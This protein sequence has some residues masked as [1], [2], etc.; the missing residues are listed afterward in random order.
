MHRY[1]R[2]IGFSGFY[3]NKE[4]KDIIK[5][6]ILF[7]DNK[8][9]VLGK[10]EVIWAEYR[11]E[12]AP[13]MG[14]AVCGEYTEENEFE[15]EYYFPYF[16]SDCVSSNEEISVEKHAD[17]DSFSGVCEDYKVGISL[18]FYLQNRMD[19]LKEY[20]KKNYSS[21]NSSVNLSGLSVSG[22]IML[23]LEKDIEQVRKSNK[24]IN[25]RKR[26][27]EKA[28]SGDEKA[29]ESLTLSDMDQ[30]N[31]VSKQVLKNDVFS[32]VDTTFMPYGVECDKYSVLG[33]IH[34]VD[35][36]KNSLTKEELYIISMYCNDINLEVCI[37]K[38]D[39]IGEPAPKRRFKGVI[40]LQGHLNIL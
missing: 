40:W 10:N 24:K 8:K 6:I 14:I 27:M 7:P 1:M 28:R 16:I 26:L 29:I 17:K 3:R 34:S 21:V 35:T 18:I 20:M 5:K 12:F 30:Y 19:Y 23:P 38:K 36:V 31:M 25:E 2:S 39:L 11:K 4:I 22:M 13:G 32:I 33:E 15:Y 37:N 9:Y